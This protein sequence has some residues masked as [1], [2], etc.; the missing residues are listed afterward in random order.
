MFASSRW[1]PGCLYAWLGRCCST[2]ALR[3]R[4][5]RPPPRCFISQVTPD[6]LC[7]VSCLSLSPSS[8]S[9]PPPPIA[10]LV[11]RIVTNNQQ[12]AA[13][14]KLPYNTTTTAAEWCTSRASA[15]NCSISIRLIMAVILIKCEQHGGKS[16][17]RRRCCCRRRHLN[18][19]QLMSTNEASSN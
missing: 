10:L 16:V 13:V 3:G 7:F 12:M 17:C 5:R 6:L 8:G 11:A 4:R 1:L 9:C 19:N 2:W 14:D 15:P 18:C